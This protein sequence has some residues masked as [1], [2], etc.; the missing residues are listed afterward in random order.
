[1]VG[2]KDKLYDFERFKHLL[3]VVPI[4]P[5]GYSF[6]SVLK[7]FGLSSVNIRVIWDGG[8]EATSISDAAMSRIMRAQEGQSPCMCALNS[9]GRFPKAQKFFGY[10][11]DTGTAVEIRG[12]L[13]LETEDHQVLPGL[14]VRMVPGQYDDL[15]VSAMD[16]DRLGWS[17]DNYSDLFELLKCGIAVPRETPVPKELDAME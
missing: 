8:A 11:E 4:P 9:M 10:K 3:P 1:M 17:R 2:P 16:L 6:A 13:R 12:R 14:W 15:L 7:A 5:K